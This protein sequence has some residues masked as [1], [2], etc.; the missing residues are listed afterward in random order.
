MSDRPLPK[1][2]RYSAWLEAFREMERTTAESHTADQKTMAE[3]HM[4]FLRMAEAPLA[5]MTRRI[6]GQAPA[7]GQGYHMGA[8]AAV[9]K[10]ALQRKSGARGLRSILEAVMLD[11]MY[12]IP[13]RDDVDECVINQEVIEQGNAPLLVLK[14][15]AESA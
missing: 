14:Q 12:E 5:N 13:S 11:L 2:P 15:E 8:L 1:D 4:Q 3:S 9:A 7:A 10:Q 6:D